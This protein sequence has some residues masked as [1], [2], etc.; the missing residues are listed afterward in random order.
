MIDSFCITAES[1]EGT[2]RLALFLYIKNNKNENLIIK[3]VKN[4]ISSFPKYKQPYWIKTITDVPQT[5][6]GKIKRNDLKIL[7]ER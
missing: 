6:T 2:H 4:R 5:A 7:I 1:E 3:L